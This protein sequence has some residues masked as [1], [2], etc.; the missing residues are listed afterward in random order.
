MRLTPTVTRF[1]LA[2]ALTVLAASPAAATTLMRAGLEKLTADNQLIVQGRVLDTRSYW[3]D[4][5]TFIFT[6]IRVTT[7]DVLK[8]PSRTSEVTFTLMGGTVGDITTLIIG[9]PE[10]VPG[11]EYVFFLGRADLPGGISRLTVRDHS[12]G[13]FNVI[14]DRAGRRVVSQAIHDPLVPDENGVDTVPG[15]EQG[16]PLDQLVREVR[17]LSIDR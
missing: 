14:V 3:N 15:G 10:I 2:L 5:H 7:D 16:M 9:G 13:V 12:Q 17:A 6:D 11:S 4:D 1:A 8:G